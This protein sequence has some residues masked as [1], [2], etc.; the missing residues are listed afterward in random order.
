MKQRIAIN[1][2][3]RI[4]RTV[5]RAWTARQSLHETVEIAAIN[6][7]AD[8]ETV[9]HLARYDS[10]HGRF[11]GTV[12]GTD[13]SLQVN[14]QRIAL[15]RQA[16]I[17][18][19]PWRDLEIDL[20]IESTGA[21]SDRLTAEQHISS[22]ARRVLFSQPAQPD[23]DATIVWGLN[24]SELHADHRVISAGSCTTN[25]L[26]P[27]LKI[28]DDAF[29]IEAGTITTVHSAMNDQPV[30]DAYHHTDLRKTRAAFHSIIPVDTGLAVGI[31]RILP[32]LANKLT[33]HALRVPTLNVSALDITLQTQLRCDAASVNHAL[34]A[35]AEGSLAGILGIATEPLA[36]CDFNGESCSG[37]I[38]ASQTQVA[39]DRLVKVLVWFDNEWAYAQRLLDIVQYVGT[40]IKR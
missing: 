9:A 25:A 14:G 15:L 7:I 26:C 16:Q 39:G 40:L 12:T 6:E 24:Q 38:D 10:T 17:D 30:L 21:F 1:G 3:G 35:A 31:P 2:F 20:V 36:S 33:A 34:V 8:P 13:D 4:G 11:P 22:G 19:L 37:V 23:V 32:K 5:L 28:I 29:G 18:N 27:V